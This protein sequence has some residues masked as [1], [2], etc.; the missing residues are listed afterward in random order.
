MSTPTNSS[1]S[2]GGSMSPTIHTP[3]YPIGASPVGP[4]LP[5]APPASSD[6][7]QNGIP[8]PNLA[9][10]AKVLYDYDAADMNEL[11]LIAD[12]VWWS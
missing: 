9:R 7:N 12:E 3:L 4:I 11:S 5:S 1:R 8:K 10:K 6:A 2:D